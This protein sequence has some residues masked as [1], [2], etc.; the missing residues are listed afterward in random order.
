MANEITKVTD[1]NGVDHPFKDLAAFP[2]SEQ[3]VLGAKNVAIGE[4]SSSSIEG[5]AFTANSDNTVGV[6][7]GSTHA[8][9]Q[10]NSTPFTAPVSGMFKYL[11]GIANEAVVFCW[12]N[13]SNSR[14]YTSP[15]KTTA[16]SNN[17]KGKEDAIPFYMEEGHVYQLICRVGANVE[18]TGTFY[19]M[20][21]CETDTDLSYAPPAMTNKEL[22]DAVVGLNGYGIIKHSIN[23]QTVGANSDLS[24]TLPRPVNYAVVI[25]SSLKTQYD[26]R[27][28]EPY[29]SSYPGAGGTSV[30]LRFNKQG[31]QELMA[32]NT[33][34]TCDV[35]LLVK[36]A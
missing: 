35:I 31:T 21:I 18:V 25:G 16:Q 4:F 7:A 32:E 2:R 36:Y 14:P 27:A 19:P 5:V 20:I 30:T 28:Y 6:V 17:S 26:N 29:V 33:S 3:A 12:D 23:A 22:T 15:S 13:T 24:I 9:H 1:Q 8:Q 11:G 10:V 34:V